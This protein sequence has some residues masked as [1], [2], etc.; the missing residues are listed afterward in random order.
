MELRLDNNYQK[1]AMF[2]LLS[3]SFARIL[4]EFSLIC[5]IVKK[6]KE[7]EVEERFFFTMI[8]IIVL[9]NYLNFGKKIFIIINF[10]QLLNRIA[11]QINF[12]GE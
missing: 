11:S 3:Y 2:L 1:V 9:C 6:K 5:F 10:S 8:W 4:H 7:E 12:I